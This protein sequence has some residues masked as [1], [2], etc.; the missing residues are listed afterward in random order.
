MN[1]GYISW[2]SKKQ[3]MVALSSTKAE[4]MSLTEA[5]QEAI[6]FKAFQCELGE[7]KSDE[8]VKVYEDN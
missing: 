4:Y 6:W 8:A 2:R 3:R 1:N 7:M 5:V